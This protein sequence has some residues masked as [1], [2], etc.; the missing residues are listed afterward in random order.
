MCQALARNLQSSYSPQIGGVGG[1]VKRRDPGREKVLRP[2]S[3]GALPDGVRVGG[4]HVATS[5][6]QGRERVRLELGT[7]EPTEEGTG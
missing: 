4:Q 2:R 5:W 7:R 3:L 1:W 6:A